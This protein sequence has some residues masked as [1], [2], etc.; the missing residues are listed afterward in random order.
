MS[1]AEFSILS[2]ARETLLAEVSD[3]HS[4]LIVPTNTLATALQA[5]FA[6]QMVAS[7]KQAWVA[8]SILTW[9]QFLQ[10]LWE[11]DV[12]RHIDYAGLRV[13]NPIQQQL[14][15]TRIIEADRRQEESLRLLNAQ[16]TAKAA[17]DAHRFCCDWELD[18]DFLQQHLTVDLERFISWR[19]EFKNWSKTRG[20]IN[21]ADIPAALK[22]SSVTSSGRTRLIFHAFDLVTPAQ[23]GTLS[24]LQT[25]GIEIVVTAQPKALNPKQLQIDIYDQDSTELKATF[26][27]ARQKLESQPDANFVIVVPD[28]Q[29]RRSEIE[30]LAR[31]VFY[32]SLTPQ[33]AQE[34]HLAYRFS[35]GKP[36]SE[37]GA[38]NTALKAL[39]LL[40]AQV[41]VLDLAAVFSSRYL[42]RSTRSME[43]IDA[44]IE[45][46]RSQRYFQITLDEL[47]ALLDGFAEQQPQFALWVESLRVL[48]E[49][50][51]ALLLELPVKVSFSEWQHCFQ[52]WLTHL[53]WHCSDNTDGLG[54]LQFQL[55]Q[56]FAELLES[57]TSLGGVQSSVGLTKALGWLDKLARDT[58]FQPQTTQSPIL[59]SGVF[60]AVGQDCDFL[61][62]TGQHEHYPGKPRLEP[63]IPRSVYAQISHPASNAQQHFRQSRKV[64]ARLQS[65]TNN[66]RFSYAAVDLAEADA[67]R[68][69]SPLFRTSK[70]E[71]ADYQS[72]PLSLLTLEAY[73]DH[74]GLPLPHPDKSSNSVSAL[75]RQS[76]CAFSAF[77]D[78]RLACREIEEPEFGLPVNLQ[79][80]LVHKLLQIVW[81]G[82][83][84]K[85]GL[86]DFFR[87]S[88]AVQDQTIDGWIMQSFLAVEP[89]V[90]PEQQG[91]LPLEQTRLHQLLG[92]WLLVELGRKADF[93]VI[94]LE[95]R[96]KGRIGELSFEGV[97][98]RVDRVAEHGAV[99]IDY[100]TGAANR[101]EWLGERMR[102]PQLPLYKHAFESTPA[103]TRVAA[104]AYAKVRKS[105]TAF[106]ELG[107][108]GIFV[109]SN[110]HSRNR[111][112]QWSNQQ[113]IWQSQ[114]L[115]LS[116]DYVNGVAKVDPI[117]NTLCSGC[118]LGSLCR[119]SQFAL[120]SEQ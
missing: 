2:A 103:N 45:W 51:K 72:S 102:N 89:V 46:L 58:I 57:F 111:A 90:G 91:L 38:I 18:D 105:D 55:E 28:L 115:Q 93:E 63:F 44:F 31:E 80:I 39:H 37:W 4:S 6:A 9:N 60:E 66:I 17:M 62:V 78:F 42:L 83:K 23:H 81:Q 32:P 79:G 106:S 95:R 1:L 114:L 54:S 21:M 68:G 36:M 15:W 67:L 56:S 87:Q 11:S 12:S 13:L 92:D 19:T 8:P 59:I 110:H 119:F 77:A 112:E 101:N 109:S 100:K 7:G 20:W 47:A 97:I 98:D 14:I 65:T 64:M 16:Q 52:S 49:G 10:S 25:K 30:H 94:E 118:A 86:E 99:L 22:D 76:N 3:P 71:Q 43:A 88:Q 29:Q 113:E 48:L 70:L 117:D 50:R 69:P 108:E 104:L 34:Q 61:Y 33:Q 116:K 73:E 74:Q 40:G 75:R 27:Q 82:L 107:E 53:S 41:S 5:S 85:T 35:L 84:D 26:Q 96:Y 120:Q 24:Y